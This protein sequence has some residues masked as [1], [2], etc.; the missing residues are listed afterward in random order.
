MAPGLREPQSEG[1]ML[2][3]FPFREGFCEVAWGHRAEVDPAGRAKA[4]RTSAVY[5]S[6]GTSAA[7]DP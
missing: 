5:P 4:P 7:T 1:D 3:A 2:P 6:L